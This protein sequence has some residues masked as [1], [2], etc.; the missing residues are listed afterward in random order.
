MAAFHLSRFAADVTVPIGHPLMGGGI[1][2]AA[3]I[4]DPLE[5]KGI[6][7][8]GAEAPIVL[9][10]VD[11]CEIRN[12]AYDRFREAL[13]DA[14]HT[15]RERVVLASIHQ[16]DAPVVDLTAERILRD[17]RAEASVCNPEF[18]ARAVDRTS[19][20]LQKSLAGARPVTQLRL[21][22]AKVEKVASN[23]RF[24][25]EQRGLSFGRTSSTTDPAAHRADEGTIDPWLKTLCFVAED[26]PLAEMHVYAT[27]PMA[28]YGRGGVSADFVGLARRRREALDPRVHPLYF[29]GASG[30]VTAGKYNDGSPQN[31]SIL[32]GRILAA[33]TAAEQ[34]AV[35]RP[36]ERV[37][38]K[39][40][41]L[42]LEPRASKGFSV[43]EMTETVRGGG[44]PF[45]QCLAAMG[46]SW[47]R[48]CAEGRPIEMPCID[49]GPARILLLP[50][51]SYVEYQL[52]AQAAR[53]DLF[54]C[55]LGYG[56]CATGYI[57]TEKAVAE[58]DTNLGDWCWVA[59]GAEPRMRAAIK[60]A[61]EA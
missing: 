42:R 36:L 16:H 44:K 2:P 39:T 5:A 25:D 21:G 15:T 18:F 59:P 54:V 29:S 40:A 3:R 52:W 58:N 11:W 51:E 33:M 56:E 50:G 55:T 17:A 14:A 46:L 26:D 19:S 23:R 12:D 10:G 38:L 43:E 13:A 31:R 32:A 37:R 20:A 1:A 27:H 57:P 53:P 35:R 61:L 34:G 47:R 41:E 48:R 30:N 7:L 4:E 9:C 60:E 6:V 22:Q 8:L 49:L 45:A 24:L 28:Y